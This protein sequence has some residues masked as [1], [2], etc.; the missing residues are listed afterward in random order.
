M[1]MEAF[2]WTLSRNLRI[3]LCVLALES[4]LLRQMD[5][6]SLAAEK[7]YGLI[8]RSYGGQTALVI[9]LCIASVLNFA[10]ATQL[11]MNGPAGLD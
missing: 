4:Q 9:S 7:Q 2:F 10:M 11:S 8:I 1:R 3:Y 5:A 6:N